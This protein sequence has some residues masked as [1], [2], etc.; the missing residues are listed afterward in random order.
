MVDP[1][2]ELEQLRKLMLQ[3]RRYITGEPDAAMSGLSGSGGTGRKR[4]AAMRYRA[5]L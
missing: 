2:R 3:R 4:A 1:Q 5:V